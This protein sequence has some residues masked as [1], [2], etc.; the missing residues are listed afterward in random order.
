MKRFSQLDLFRDG[1]S[2]Q[3]S[4]ALRWALGKRDAAEARVALD[5][6]AAAEPSHRWLAPARRLIEALETPVPAGSE[7]ALGVFLRLDGE[8]EDAAHAVF[9]EEP[10]ELLAPI[11]RAVGEAIEERA[12]E[13]E[14]PTRHASYA[15]MRAGDWA[16]AERC[17]REVREYRSHPALLSRMA[18]AVWYQRRWV[19]A[20]DH[21]FALCWHSPEA[22]HRLIECGAVPDPSLKRAWDTCRDL[23]VEPEISA[24]WF[25]AWMML[26]RP[27][28]ARM[29][30]APC[31]ESPA[32]EAFVTMLRLAT[33]RGSVA[34]LRKRLKRLH[35]GLLALLLERQ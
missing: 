10:H 24:A 1:R 34:H 20:A 14:H 30:A 16:N 15:W 6:L 7:E 26:H 13:P 9:G 29:A 2:V 35:P 8:F 27:G 33:G 18:E 31:G 11:W 21:W 32:E 22:F 4:N 28:L 19:D 3:A 12:F 23:D 25:P 5:E 17:I